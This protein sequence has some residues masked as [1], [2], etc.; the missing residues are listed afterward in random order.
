MDFNARISQQ[1]RNPNSNTNNNNGRTRKKEDDSDAFMRLV[2]LTGHM[3]RSR[4][5]RVLRVILAR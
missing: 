1:F 2:S 4:P 5:P 3:V